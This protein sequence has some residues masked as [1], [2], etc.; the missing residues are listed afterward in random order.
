MRY[1]GPAYRAHSPK[2]SW[3]PLSGEGALRHGG[4]FNRRGRPALYLAS[5]LVTAVREFA[6]AFPFKLVPPITIVSYEV[7][8]DHIVDLTQPSVRRQMKFTP[9]QLACTDWRT[10]QSDGKPVPSQDISE[11]LIG[12]GA[13]GILVR[14]FAPGA[15]E[16]DVNLVLWKWSTR[17]PHKIAVHDPDGALPKDGK[18]WGR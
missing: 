4:R 11:R 3:A 12:D 7:D 1:R 8:C 13:A 6:Q 9:S 18:S 17:L 2:W 15:A 16:N 10:L 14:S 5:D